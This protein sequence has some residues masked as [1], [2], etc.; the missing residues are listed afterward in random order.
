M[1]DALDSEASEKEVDKKKLTKILK[2]LIMNLMK[3]RKDDKVKSE[4]KSDK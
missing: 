4:D 3:S 1:E 2:M